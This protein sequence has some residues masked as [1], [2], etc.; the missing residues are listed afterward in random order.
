MEFR[1]CIDLHE[2]KV[3]Q[4]VGSSL[5]DSGAEENFVSQNDADYYAELYKKAG[6]YGGHIIAL[7]SGNREQIEKA[8]AAY[9]GGL[10]VGG[11]INADNARWYIEKGASHVIVTSFIFKDGKF[12]FDN[13][14]EIVK[15]VNKENLVIDLSCRKKDGKYYVV[16][17]K[18]QKFT[19]FEVNEENID[20]LSE[21]CDEFLVHAVDVE[22][23]RNGIDEELIQKLSNWV[24]IPCTYAGGISSLEDVKYIESISGGRMNYTIG[25]ALDI[26]GGNIKFHDVINL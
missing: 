10:Q 15:V 6:L 26:F 20:F 7:G 5:N 3:K 1:P 11:G 8:L 12:Y 19:N 25:S 4:I 9:P 22:G 23:L 13:L 21:F 17:N 14:E 2:G 18:W 24:K 16:T